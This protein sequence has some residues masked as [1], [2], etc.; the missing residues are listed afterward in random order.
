MLEHALRIRDLV[1]G[2][3]MHTEVEKGVINHRFFQRLREVRQNGV[4]LLAYP[5]LATSRFT[6]SLG[7]CHIAG[8]IAE[9]LT[10]SPKWPLYLRQLKKLKVGK[11]PGINRPDDFVQVAR[12]YALLHDI[13]HLPLSHLFEMAMES[14]ARSHDRNLKSMTTEWFGESAFTKPH[15]ALGAILVRGIVRDVPMRPAVARCLLTLMTEK[16]LPASHPLYPL[17]MLVDSDIDADRIDATARDGLLAGGEYGNHDIDRLS[18]SMFLD[19]VHGVWCLAYSEKAV[20]SMEALLFDRY[21]THVWIHFHHRVVAANLLVEVLV[22]SLLDRNI[23]RKEDFN[24]EGDDFL[25]RDDIWLWGLIRNADFSGDPLMERVRTALLAREKKHMLTL[26]KDRIKFRDMDDEVRRR[27]MKPHFVHKIL[28]SPQYRQYMSEMTGLLTLVYK[29]PFGVEIE[30]NIAL[31][32]EKSK[33]LTAKY[34]GETS[35][36]I[37]NLQ[38]LWENE[39]QY[40]VVLFG[41]I[42][43]K[44]R[45]KYEREWIDATAKWVRD[46]G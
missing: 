31:Y 41:D 4:S 15:E 7:A 38:G 17:K 18:S 11:T 34:L 2:F 45:E 35:K 6:H 43:P 1:H 46:H 33:T 20:S 30:R 10:A 22:G 21:R 13:G 29:P 39:P 24:P 36:I 8:E 42:K 12:L 27:A 25:Y 28:L 5:S 19:E 9:R 32:S 3:T 37:Q 40:H 14:H 16:S 44:E 23:L 26:W